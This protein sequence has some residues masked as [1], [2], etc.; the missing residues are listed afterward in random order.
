MAS[1]EQTL[2]VIFGLAAVFYIGMSVFVSRNSE[3]RANDS[4]GYLL[5]LIGAF[6]A[7]AALWYGAA[8]LNLFRVG[9]VLTMF[10]AGFMPV[11]FYLLYREYAGDQPSRHLIATLSIIPSV[12]TGLAITNPWHGLLWDAALVDGVV[13]FSHVRD[14][15]WFRLVSLPFVYSLFGYSLLALAGRLPSIARAH[16]SRVVILLVCAV[17]PFLVNVANTLLDV[18]PYDF[19]WTAM[20]LVALLPLYWWA[21]VRLRVATFKPVAY[22]TLFDHV[23]DAILVLDDEKR[24]VSV[25]RRGE[26]LLDAAESELVG[27]SID[28]VAGDIGKE[29]RQTEG[30]NL[31]GTV[32]FDGHS[33]LDVSSAPL[34]GSRGE[35]QGMV[36]VWRDITERRKTQQALA[37]SEQLIRS[38]VENSSNGMLRFS[39]RGTRFRCSFANR[40]AADFLNAGDS[41]LVGME[42]EEFPTLKPPELMERFGVSR[43]RRR[44]TDRLEKD[45]QTRSG[46]RWLRLVAEPVGEDFSVTLIDITDSKAAESRMM[47]EAL[48][49]P[50]TGVL[51]RRGFE[52]S[53]P[54]RFANVERGAVIYLDLDNFKTVND[55]YGHPAGDTLLKAFGHRLTFCLRPEDVVGRL[56]GDEFAIMLPDIS[57][58]H[59]RIVARRLVA[60]AHRCES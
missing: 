20:A 42:L 35:S 48:Q 50:L 5:L 12:T 28:D 2:P 19:P 46:G 38:L 52:E 34:V 39:R 37:D 30:P 55:T 33:Y 9:R 21:A 25:N 17:T 16:R 11:G 6:V 10:A 13:R 32:S 56:G 4:I 14:H 23:Q 59:A 49:D 24:V 29:I 22:Q 36:V 60:S 54:V 41:E 1:F 15:A 57:E 40:A 18:G 44:S 7:G 45:V 43:T 51:N 53:V 27:R 47:A 26:E 31:S 58:D 8:D 3:D